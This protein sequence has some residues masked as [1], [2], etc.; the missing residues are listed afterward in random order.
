MA[1]WTII[2]N[3]YGEDDFHHGGD[4]D[5]EYTSDIFER[6][7]YFIHN[8]GTSFSKE[9]KEIRLIVCEGDSWFQ[10]AVLLS[11]IKAEL[12][13]KDKNPN[14]IWGMINLA[15][16]SATLHSMLENRQTNIL[17]QVLA[18]YKD[19]IKCVLLSAG[20]NDVIDSA[21]ELLAGKDDITMVKIEKEYGE[22]CQII[23]TSFGNKIDIFTHS[24]AY[25]CAFG[26]C[27]T[28]NNLMEAV[29][30]RLAS[31]CPWIKPHI[32][33][34]TN[35]EEAMKKAIDDLFETMGRVSDIVI[36]DTREQLQDNGQ[37]NPD[38]WIDEIHP[39]KIGMKRIAKVYVEKILETNPKLLT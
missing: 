8:V 20:G 6:I 15:K 38:Y 14:T 7:D 3:H 22:M 16:S 31:D 5:I 28:R 23:N 25:L 17:K 19:H 35:P 2:D 32:A 11:M 9:E 13:N 26:K 29:L 39:K 21:A 1:T 27:D 33:N 12:E 24:Y 10:Y 30:V 4:S 34:L 37:N 18:Q 36:A